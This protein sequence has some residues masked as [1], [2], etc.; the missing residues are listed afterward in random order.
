[1]YIYPNTNDLLVV[2]NTY[3]TIQEEITINDIPI[4]KWVNVILRCR[5][6]TMD[7]YINGTKIL[8]NVAFGT[9]SPFL[10]VPLGTAAL[11]VTYVGKDE[12]IISANLELIAKSWY[13]ALAIGSSVTQG[14]EKLQGLLIAD[15]ANTPAAG[16]GKVME[17]TK[18][19]EVRRWKLELDIF[20]IDRFE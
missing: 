14:D 13:S 19:I 9:S 3:D 10:S 7:V 18:S 17:C 2:M 20:Y 4:G 16:K 11:K 15:L 5:D 12:A 8:S 1:M 6:K